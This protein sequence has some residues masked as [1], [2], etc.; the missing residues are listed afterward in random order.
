MINSLT[1]K[2]EKKLKIYKDKW[3]AI[4]L[5]TDRIDRKSAAENFNL[6]NEKVLKGKKNPTI[7]F[8]DSP[9]T[10]WLAL[11]LINKYI[12]KGKNMSRVWSKVW[13]QVGSQVESQVWSKVDSRVQSRVG[14]QVWSKVDSRV[15]SRVQ[16][17]V[18]SQVG[19]RVRSQVWSQF[20]SFIYPYLG[21][22]FDSGHF[23]HYDFL[24]KELNIKFVKEWE[25]YLNT[26]KVSLIYPLED[27]CIIS[28]KPT[29]I[30]MRNSVLHNETGPAISY[31]DGLSI[32]ALNG[33]KVPREIVDTSAENLDPTLLIKESNAEIRR[34]IIK[35]IG[36]SR[37]LQKLEAKKLDSWMEYELYRMENIDIEPVQVLKM[38]CPSTGAFHAHRVPP[39]IKSAREGIKWINHGIDKEE[40]LAER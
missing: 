40:F 1:D 36:M 7:V 8:M 31:A 23:S 39:E 11:L 14:S 34:E 5:S 15:Q 20:G 26:S 24:N 38:R 33:V 13:L 12:G 3:L 21:G 18:E 37:I 9:L 32:Y 4:G 16:S 29:S 19:S 35:K 2:Q 30:K 28:E 22:Q 27:F 10:T 17:Q 6:F 25:L